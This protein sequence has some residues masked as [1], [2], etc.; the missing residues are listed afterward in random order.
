MFLWLNRSI[1]WSFF[2]FLG[3]KINLSKQKD[4][5][6][7]SRSC[8]YIFSF[9]LVKLENFQIEFVTESEIKV[10]SKFMEMCIFDLVECGQRYQR[11][12][13]EVNISTFS[14]YLNQT[15]YY[16][17]K[18]VRD[19]TLNKLKLDTNLVIKCL[20]KISGKYTFPMWVNRLMNFRDTQI[21]PLSLPS[22]YLHPFIYIFIYLFFQNS[23]IRF[24]L[25]HRIHRRLHRPRF[26]TT[27]PHTTF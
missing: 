18:C 12:S 26:T 23:K 20:K 25:T 24:P 16:S 3:V 17:T 8:C 4:D 19:R 27:R 6:F 9:K 11:K 22:G 7:Y 5:I 14:T 1:G 10:D 21:K 15:V 2:S 13:P